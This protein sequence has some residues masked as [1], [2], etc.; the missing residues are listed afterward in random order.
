MG[1]GSSAA[2]DALCGHPSS[3]RGTA[4][5]SRD[6]EFLRRGLNHVYLTGFLAADPTRDKGR[7]GEPVDLLWVAF[8]APD[9]SDC[10]E[11]PEIASCEIEVPQQVAQA[12]GDE[13]RAGMSIFVVGQLS[14]GGGVIATELHSGP[15]SDSAGS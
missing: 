9:D 14:G 11:H 2:T 10:T 8:P 15:A 1:Q 6:Q 5:A 12:H 13:L 7:D 3:L 4:G